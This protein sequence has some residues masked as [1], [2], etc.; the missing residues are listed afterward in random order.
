MGERVVGLGQGLGHPQDDRDR[1]AELVGEPR[2]QLVPSRGPLD[3]RRLGL[4]ELSSPA[5]LPLEGL[6][7]LPDDPGGDLG[8]ED[9]TSQGGVQDGAQDLVAVGILQDVPRSACHE[10]LS[11]D[12]LVLVS[13]QRDDAEG[14]MQLFQPPGGLDPVHVR[15]AHVHQDDVGIDHRHELQGLGAGTGLAHHVEVA[16]L[17]QGEQRLP[18]PGVV[19]HHDDPHPTAGGR[20]R[21]SGGATA[22]VVRAHEGSVGH[23]GPIGISDGLPFPGRRRADSALATSA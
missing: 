17:E 23:R 10:H 7:E 4:L 1:R 18:E 3:Q 20:R 11:D 13:G 15:H 21:L 14:R 5:A 16:G 12:V 9:A 8:R 19:V 6:R 22:V 2:H